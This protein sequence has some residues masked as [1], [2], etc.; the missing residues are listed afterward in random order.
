MYI[1]LKIGN[2]HFESKEQTS[3]LIKSSVLIKHAKKKNIER[4]D[5]LFYVT[6]IN[7]SKFDGVSGFFFLNFGFV[8]RS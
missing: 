3:K 2:E 6:K 1:D 8:V 7:S 5:A 4:C